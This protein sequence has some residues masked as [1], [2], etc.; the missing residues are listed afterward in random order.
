MSLFLQSDLWMDDPSY[1]AVHTTETL[2][3]AVDN[4]E[5]YDRLYH[6]KRVRS[7]RI[8][9]IRNLMRCNARFGEK[10]PWKSVTLS[11]LY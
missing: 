10:H 7:P 4:G 6:L 11:Q 8:I 2:C 3:D 5:M 1:N 9:T